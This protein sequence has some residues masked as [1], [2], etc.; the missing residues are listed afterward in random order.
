MRQPRHPI[1]PTL[2]RSRVLSTLFPAWLGLAGAVHGE[3]LDGA[4]YALGRGLELPALELTFSGYSSLRARNLEGAPSRLDLRDLS[5]F[6]RWQPTPRWH[7]FSEVEVENLFVADDRGFTADDIEVAVER[8]YAEYLA[9]SGLSVRAGRYLTPFGRWNLVHA[10]PLVWTVSRPLV[11]MLAIPDHGTGLAVLGNTE[12]AGNSLEYTLYVDDSDDLDPV[13]GE[14]DFEDVVAPGLPND[15]EYAGGVQLRY[16]F[17][18]EQAEVATSYATYELAGIEGQL[19]ALGVDGIVRWRRFEFSFEAAY[20]VNDARF[21]GDDWGAFAQ[22]VIPIAGH[23]Y[24]IAR[25]EYYRTAILDREATRE[26]LGLAYRPLP[27]LNFK[28]EFHDGDDAQLA[29]DGLEVSL[30]ILF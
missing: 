7:V 8:I 26:S 5:L 24:G 13:N 25:A 14:A 23:V 10:E 15:F 27:P 4:T 28:F 19:H 12:V 3:P 29:P 11:T 2:L 16:H 17:F 6:T 22:A 20:R 18:D 30:S 1:R 21:A 9:A